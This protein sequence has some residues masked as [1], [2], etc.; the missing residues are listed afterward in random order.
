MYNIFYTRYITFNLAVGL[1]NEAFMKT[2]HQIF[3]HTLPGEWADGLL[4]S[5][6]HFNN[7]PV[8]RSEA[9]TD[10]KGEHTSKNK[11][12]SFSGTLTII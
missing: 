4:L 11:L 12:C 3:F 8:S 7:M 9:G 10:E 6:R 5:F 2:P 1:D